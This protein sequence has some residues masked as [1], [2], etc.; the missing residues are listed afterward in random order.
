MS[1]II[2]IVIDGL[3]DEPIPQ[4]KG[5]TPL[6]AA[7]T[8]NLDFLA[9]NGIC[10]QVIPWIEKG[11]LPTSEDTHLAIF[12]YDPKKSN[13][14]RGVLEALGINFK[15]RKNDICFRGNFA[16][17]DDDLTIIDRRAGRIEKTENLISAL[18]KI[19]VK[20]AKVIVKKSFGHRIV[21]VLRGKNLSEK[22][23]KNDPKKVG[24]KVLRIVPKIKNAKRT[25]QILNQF[26][27]KARF[28]LKNHPQ[29]KKRIKEGK[30]PANFILL[31]GAGKFRKVKSFK[32]KYKLRAAFIAGGVLY[33]GIGKYLKMKEIKVRGAN[34]MKNTNL[35]GK[36]L[37]LKKNIRK[38]D[39]IFL[40][41][42]ATDTFAEDGDFLGKKNFIEKI[43]R[44]LKPILKLKDVLIVITG[45]HPTSCLKKSH[46][47][48]KNPVLIFGNGKDK[49]E[50]F[51][52]KNC[53]KG[54]FGTLSQMD[55]LRKIFEIDKKI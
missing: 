49:V 6:E 4:F 8:P 29:N 15:L 13:P 16:T 35:K 43:D 22:I 26:L 23:T 14:G 55:L 46:A 18:N 45:D 31:R 30:L 28:I 24:V 12:G 51:S 53:Q 34:G 36:I 19:K 20:G 25:V 48:G 52:E 9:E 33:K 27:E 17:V 11:K 5:K 41:I 42:K 39:F 37:A 44:N 21:L 40:H 3:A 2:L 38:F 47:F 50:K 1:K 54:D 10:G 32:E 7:K